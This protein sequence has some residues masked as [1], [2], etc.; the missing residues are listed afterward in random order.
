MAAKL[1]FAFFTGASLAGV[2]MLLLPV[3]FVVGCENQTAT[4]TVS[5]V[6]GQVCSNTAGNLPPNTG[7]PQLVYFYRDT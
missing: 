3:L 6:K 4:V 7:K 2:F 5:T 1:K